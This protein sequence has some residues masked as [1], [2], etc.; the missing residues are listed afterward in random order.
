MSRDE[1]WQITKNLSFQNG[2]RAK[3]QEAEHAGQVA[4][5]ENDHCFPAFFADKGNPSK[6]NSPAS[7]C[8]SLQH[9]QSSTNY[10]N[11]S[12]WAAVLDGIAELKNHLDENGEVQDDTSLDDMSFAEQGGP[13]LLYG[14]SRLVTKEEILEA[15]PERPVVDRLISRYFNSFEMSPVI[16]LGL[17]FTIM[18]LA[19]QF[20]K[21]RLDP[22]IQTPASLST[23]HDLQGK[24]ELYRQ[25]VVQC[26]VLGEYAKGGPYVLETLM[27]YIAMELFL[28]S[29]AEIGVWIL[30]GTIVQLAMHMGYH[31]DPRHFPSMSPFT[32]EMRKRVWATIVELDLGLSTQMGLPRLIK[33][34]QTDTGGPSNLHDNDFDRSTA[35]M[36][37]SRPKNELTPM[38]YRLVK[39]SMVAAIGFVWDLATDTRPCSYTEIMKM[40]NMLQD[41][42]SAI[43]ACLQWRSMAH[44]IMDSPQ[45][46]MQ[47]VFLEI[48]F[49]RA[50]IVLHQR[51][52]HRW[53]ATLQNDYSQQACLDAALKLL[54]YQHVLQEETQPFCRLYQERWRVSSL[55]NHDFLLATSIL[56]SYL[57]QAHAQGKG[58]AGSVIEATIWTS[59]QKTYDIWLHSSSSSK[60]AQKAAKALSVVLG[61][62]SYTNSDKANDETNSL[63]S[64]VSPPA[65]PND[66]TC[67]DSQGSPARFNIQFPVFDATVLANW[68][69]TYDGIESF[70]I[71]TPASSVDWQM[72]D[73]GA[74]GRQ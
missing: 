72:I 52:L 14:C 74:S 15:I 67:T 5:V 9:T 66:T 7:D 51:N 37:A 13:Q 24:I 11:S 73:K 2:G 23:E 58:G 48:M 35:A 18:C 19:I 53:Q 40:D 69:P 60:E 33:H 8:G 17:L 34:W 71:T 10:V 63:L 50:R 25:K 47:K 45:M 6:G 57:Q 27:L 65:F 16:W 3:Q 29:D 43:P 4:D 62:H 70:P 49:H 1:I 44:C 26:L 31:R 61:N 38:L 55:I 32:A 39:A 12:H 59:L 64:Q 42:H 54:D 56:C 68:S 20:Q 41:A 28:R 46:I 36:P 30:L 22:G 21:S